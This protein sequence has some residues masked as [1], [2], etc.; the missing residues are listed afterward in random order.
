MLDETEVT[1]EVT[2]KATLDSQVESSTP[3]FDVEALQKELKKTREEAAKY[4]TK[5]KER[6]TEEAVKRG[7]LESL[8]NQEA[9][10]A[11]QLEAEVTA[12]QAQQQEELESITSAWKEEDCIIPAS[13]S[14][15]EKLKLAK[16]LDAK[17]KA[18]VPSVGVTGAHGAREGKFNGYSSNNEWASEDPASYLEYFK[19]KKL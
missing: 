4:R 6:E 17:Y 10:R 3:Q 19:T 16:R 1:Q 12:F 15:S 13:L 8:Y 7:E 2:D 11:K 14:L 18:A 9:E 5:L